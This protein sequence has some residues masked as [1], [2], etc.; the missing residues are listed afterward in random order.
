MHACLHGLARNKL[1]IIFP[2]T[3]EEASRALK[4]LRSSKAPLVKK[5]QVMRAMAGDYRKKMEDESKKQYKL[6]QGGKHHYIRKVQSVKCVELTNFS[7]TE[8]ASAQVKTTL[9]SPKKCVFHR[10]A[11][12]K[13][14]TSATGEQPQQPDTQ[15]TGQDAKPF[16]FT[17]SKEDFCFNFF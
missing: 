9:E 10:R 17:S 6:I 11:V 15:M 13:P 2:H 4:T 16:V 7:L 5:R 12:G 14:Q 3:E 1:E 8:V